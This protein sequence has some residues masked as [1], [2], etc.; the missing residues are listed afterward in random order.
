MIPFFTLYFVLYQE[1]TFFIYVL[2]HHDVRD[3]LYLGEGARFRK[4]FLIIESS[5]MLMT[6]SVSLIMTNDTN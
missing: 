2:D 4:I 6:R 3:N 5:D 1:L